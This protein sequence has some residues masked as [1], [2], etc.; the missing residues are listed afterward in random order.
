M[1]F[2]LVEYS[3][4]KDLFTKVRDW[5]RESQ[6]KIARCFIGDYKIIEIHEDDRLLANDIVCQGDW[7]SKYDCK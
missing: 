5:F 7:R 6:W 3:S 4:D 2:Y 1:L